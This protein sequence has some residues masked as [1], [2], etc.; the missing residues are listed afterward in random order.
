MPGIVIGVA[1]RE[2]RGDY[3]STIL[4]PLNASVL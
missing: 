3:V 4:P 1:A 2:L